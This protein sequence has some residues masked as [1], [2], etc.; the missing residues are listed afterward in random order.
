MNAKNCMDVLNLREFR[1][2]TGGIN[3]RNLATCSLSYPGM[4]MEPR[5]RDSETS[6]GQ[7]AMMG[8]RSVPSLTEW[9]LQPLLLTTWLP[10]GNSG[11]LLWTTLHT[12][13]YLSVTFPIQSRDKMHLCH[14]KEYIRCKKSVVHWGLVQLN[15]REKIPQK[16][17]SPVNIFEP[18]KRHNKTLFKVEFE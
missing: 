6:E 15:L 17:I 5:A 1:R 7:S 4:P 12:N 13:S 14:D 8:V 16:Q 18:E 3:W 11:F 2:K 10:T 9:L